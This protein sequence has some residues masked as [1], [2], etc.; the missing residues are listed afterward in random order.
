AGAPVLHA[1]PAGGPAP[2]RRAGRP[3]AATRPPPARALA[4]GGRIDA[5]TRRAPLRRGE[6]LDQFRWRGGAAR[7]AGIPFATHAAPPLSPVLARSSA[8]SGRD[9]AALEH[10]G[11]AARPPARAGE[12]APGAGA[13]RLCPRPQRV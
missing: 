3:R 13:S 12:A 2:L 10:R 7:G 5:I 1:A 8:R 4:R 11:R 9:G 6:W